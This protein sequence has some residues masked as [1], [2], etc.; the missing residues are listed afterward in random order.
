MPGNI[1][2]INHFKDLEWYIGDSKMKKLIK[3]LNK[4]GHKVKKNKK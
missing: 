1:I 3:V 4:I 2:T